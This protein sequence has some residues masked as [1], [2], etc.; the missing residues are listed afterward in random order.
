MAASA[1]QPDDEEINPDDLLMIVV[2]ATPRAELVDRPLA[3]T[4][5]EQID[6]WID[7]S[8]CEQP[9]RPLICTDLWFLNDEPLQ[10]RP[11]IAIGHPS[12]NAVSALLANRLPSAYV[13]EQQFE[14]QMDAELLDLQA[15]LWGANQRGTASAVNAFTE[16]YL[17]GF[18]RAAH[19]M[20]LE[21]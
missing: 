3:L 19:G 21:A 20:R 8:G 11:T 7:L 14:V 6:R 18:L 16:R 10:S 17:D 12:V 9:L 4:L 15:C 5:R 1:I 13:I 2:G